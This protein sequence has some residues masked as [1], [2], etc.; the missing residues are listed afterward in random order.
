[1]SSLSRVLETEVMDSH[2]EA[3]D[4]DAMDHSS[5]NRLFAEDL[6]FW[7]GEA[8][9]SS[10]FT[11][12]I[13]DVGTGT[14]QIPIEI[15]RRLPA[16]RC[17]GVDL[18]AEM[19]R[20]GERNVRAAGL[21][22]S[23]RLQTADA[24]SLP[25]KDG[26]F[27]VVV[28]NSVLHHL[29]E[30]IVAFREMLRVVRRGGVLFVRDLIRPADEATRQRLVETYAANANPHQRALFAASLHAA[31]TLDEVRSMVSQLGMP[32]WWTVETSDRHWTVAGRPM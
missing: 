11:I 3:V 28:S 31:L 26:S 29:A 1:M 6:Q 13:L 16:V 9:R 30:P 20:I 5:V 12:R 17:T 25:F 10:D 23:I 22:A 19:L 7:L 8:P 27:S 18:S 15:C 4:Y 21:D 14:A 32:D 24:K 2:E